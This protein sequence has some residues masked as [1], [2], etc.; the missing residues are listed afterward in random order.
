MK[1]KVKVHPS[2][3]KQK[4][5]TLGDNYE[6]YLKSEAKNNKANLELINLL[7]KHFQTNKSRIKIKA[8]LRSRNK[9]IEILK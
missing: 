1:I 4:I 5:L 6:V 8:G 7:S 3:K 2:S 9:I